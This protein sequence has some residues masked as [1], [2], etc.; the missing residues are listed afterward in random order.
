M[1]QAKRIVCVFLA[2]LMLV[3]LAPWG[4]SAAPSGADDIPFTDI[5]DHW[6][7]DS[8][9]FVHENGI[10]HGTTA[11][12]FSPDQSFSREMMTATLF[13]LYHDRVADGSDS[14]VHPFTDVTGWAA[15]YIAWAYDAGLI[16]GMTPTSFA[17]TAPISRQ[18]SVVMLYRLAIFLGSRNLN[19]PGHADRFPDV[20][21]VGYWAENAVNW[22]VYHGFLRGIGENLAPAGTVDRAQAATLLGRFALR[23]T[24]LPEPL[25]LCPEVEAKILRDGRWNRID[26]YFGTYNGSVAFIQ[27]G[28]AD[29]FWAEEVAGRVFYYFQLH[30]IYVWNDGAFYTLSRQEWGGFTLETPGAYELGLLT[31]EDIWSIH[32]HHDLWLPWNR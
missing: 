16:N 12:T 21:L 29:A 26:G 31:T 11:T 2:F 1:K 32:F 17:P 22:A 5:A 7:V 20:H 30:R 10:M 28:V 27:I 25:V 3:A 13:R 6:A 4:V 24:H 9:H 15:P 18:D 8:I 23:F 14:T 19:N